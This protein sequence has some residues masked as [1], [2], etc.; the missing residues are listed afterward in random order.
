MSSSSEEEILLPVPG[1]S[2]VVTG[3]QV[4]NEPIEEEPN[5]EPLSHWTVTM[6]AEC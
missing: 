4:E 3:N 6:K 1:L 5:E 2:Q